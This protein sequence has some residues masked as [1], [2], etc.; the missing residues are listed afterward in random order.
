MPQVQELLPSDER[1]YQRRQPRYFPRDMQALIHPDKNASCSVPSLTIVVDFSLQGA[2]LLLSD[3]SRLPEPG[4]LL[5]LQVDYEGIITPVVQARVIH[6]RKYGTFAHL[7]L[8][9]SPSQEG[10][11][12]FEDIEMDCIEKALFLF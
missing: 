9:Y 4:D 3:I 11:S 12:E 6:R 1:D 5:E 2:G 8:A 7:G 10:G